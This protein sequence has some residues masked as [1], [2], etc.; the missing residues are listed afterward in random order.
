VESG[1]RKQ[2]ATAPQSNQLTRITILAAAQIPPSV[3]PGSCDDC[4]ARRAE[5]R[6]ERDE[7]VHLSFRGLSEA[8]E[9]KKT[10]P[11]VRRPS[12]KVRRHNFLT[13]LFQRMRCVAQEP[14][15]GTIPEKPLAVC[16]MVAALL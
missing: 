5:S 6:I 3:S 15:V 10:N 16:S 11:G 7:R 4:C 13:F 14:D 2:L 1:P 8:R 12:T 9:K